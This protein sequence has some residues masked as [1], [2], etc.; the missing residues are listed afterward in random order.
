M[1][2]SG[3]D[4]CDTGRDGG[5]VCK[6]HCEERVPWGPV[7][8]RTVLV[9]WLV[10]LESVLPR[11]VGVVLQNICVY[12]AGILGRRGAEQEDAGCHGSQECNVPA[13]HTLRR[14]RGGI[15]VLQIWFVCMYVCISFLRIVLCVCL[16]LCCCFSYFSLCSN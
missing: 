16:P 4:R 2:M 9:Q 7:L 15:V 13:F 14:N 10:L 1:A 6:G 8:D 12:S 11:G 5:R 3:S